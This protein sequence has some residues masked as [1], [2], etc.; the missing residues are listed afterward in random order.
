MKLDVFCS[1]HW[2]NLAGLLWLGPEMELLLISD[3]MGFKGS[4]SNYY[5]HPFKNIN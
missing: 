1:V 3:V 5:V 2:L 4:N